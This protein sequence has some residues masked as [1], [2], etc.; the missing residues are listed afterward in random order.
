MGATSRFK[1]EGSRHTIPLEAQLLAASCGFVALVLASAIFI[2][3][4]RQR[5]RR[6]SRDF[7]PLIKNGSVKPSYFKGERLSD[8]SGHSM[9]PIQS[10]G[11]G[12]SAS[13]QCTPMTPYSSFATQDVLI[14]NKHSNNN[15]DDRGSISLSMNYD[16][17]SNILQLSILACHN[18]PNLVNEVGQC[19]LNSYV[20]LRILPDNQHRVK[21][22]VLRGTQNPF[23]DEQFTLYNITPVKLDS[24]SIH[25]AVLASDP[26]SRDVVLGEVFYSLRDA[27]LSKSSD[28]QNVDLK[29]SPRPSYIDVNSQVLVSMAYNS[30]SNNINL[31][32]LKMKD[33]PTFNGVGQIDAYAKVYLLLDGQRVAKQK[34]HVKKKSVEPVFNE[35]FSF[36]IP[37]INGQSA[38]RLKSTEEMLS[39]LSF[40]V[41]VLNHDGVTRNEIVGQCFILPRSEHWKAMVES[42]GQQV[43]EWHKI[44]SI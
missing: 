21:T 29:L 44:N 1:A 41:L 40:E 33:L 14:A 18:L 32:I 39:S 5:E 20:K 10:P 23:Y 30:H 11:S 35:S 17:H 22:R 9:S 42:N 24:F 15:D 4:R 19:T 8:H 7:S 38:N 3:I 36:D 16:R 28:K 6:T 12:S 37:S 13:P 2:A 43:A 26:Y 27:N 34:S 25:L 31:A